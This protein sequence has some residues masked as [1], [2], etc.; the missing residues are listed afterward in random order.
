MPNTNSNLDE[1]LATMKAIEDGTFSSKPK[2][3]E[4]DGEVTVTNIERHTSNTSGKKSIQL[5]L[6]TPEGAKF[7]TWMTLSE[8]FIK[9]TIGTLGVMVQKAGGDI[10]TIEN[11]NEI[12][13]DNE[14]AIVYM[15]NLQRKI[16]KGAKIV[17]WAVRKKQK[18]S[19]FFNCKIT[20]SKPGGSV[21][22]EELAGEENTKKNLKIDEVENLSEDDFAATV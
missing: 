8:K 6:T 16:E 1:I 14:R 19:D 5:E 10:K 3:Q 17:V 7:K 9:G 12:E 15:Q 2:V 21:T 11:A 18:D 20:F 22:L 4:Y 13:N